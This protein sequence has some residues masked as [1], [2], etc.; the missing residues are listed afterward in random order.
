LAF[1]E[2]T[3]TDSLIFCNGTSRVCWTEKRKKETGLNAKY[4][5]RTRALSDIIINRME[6]I[7]IK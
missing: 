1:Y 6:I 3:A 4:S 7:L 2:I 5:E